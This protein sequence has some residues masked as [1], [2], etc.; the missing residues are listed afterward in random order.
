MNEQEP[1]EESSQGEEELTP[2]EGDPLYKICGAD[3]NGRVRGMG[4]GVTPSMFKKSNLNVLKENEAIKVKNKKLED[5]VDAL[6]KEN[7]QIKEKNAMAEHTMS[8]FRSDLATF[9]EWTIKQ[10][11]N[12]N[13]GVLDD[14]VDETLLETEIQ[15]CSK[16]IK[17]FDFHQDR[18]RGWPD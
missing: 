2:L 7:A 16:K 5:K 4:Y 11:G 14:D 10:I 3:K 6:E 15:Q 17:F 13:H 9:K 8:E 18:F 1:N 12:D